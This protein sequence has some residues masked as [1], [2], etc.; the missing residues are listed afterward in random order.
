MEVSW[1]EFDK[2][3]EGALQPKSQL[4]YLVDTMLSMLF[5][6]DGAYRKH[7]HCKKVGVHMSNR[8]GLGVIEE[9][10]HGILVDIDEDGFVWSAVD[11]ATAVEDDEAHTHA[12]FTAELC[13]PEE[14][15]ATFDVNEI[16][17]VAVACSH[18]NSALAA[19]HVV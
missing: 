16:E 10:V 14:G 19:A 15:L 1:A 13:N 11:Q 4:V 17:I 7:V 6:L 2:V 5:L 9:S 12:K 8:D 18:T 3:Y